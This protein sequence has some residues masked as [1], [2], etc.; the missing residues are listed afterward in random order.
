[1]SSIRTN[2]GLLASGFITSELGTIT[3]ELGTY[4]HIFLPRRLSIYIVEVR[5][6]S[7]EDPAGNGR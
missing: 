5:E 4:K 6:L 2:M 7:K 3:S 1:M